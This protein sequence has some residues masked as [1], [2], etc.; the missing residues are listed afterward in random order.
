MR[1]E[2]DAEVDALYIEFRP[3]AAG[4]AEARTLSEDITGNFAPDGKLAGLE[5]LDASKVLGEEVGKVVM[6]LSPMA[7][8]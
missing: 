7:R 3:L 2:Y 8:H 4:T 1:I 5:I 6:E